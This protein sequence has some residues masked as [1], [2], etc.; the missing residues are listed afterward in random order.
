MTHSLIDMP[1]SSSLVQPPDLMQFQQWLNAGLLPMIQ[2][3]QQIRSIK[4]AWNLLSAGAELMR[5]SN[6]NI[7]SIEDICSKAGTTVGAFYGRFQNK[8]AFFLALQKLVLLQSEENMNR[9]WRHR[10]YESQSL[11]DVCALLVTASV[12]RY[13]QNQG[14]YRT[15]LQRAHEGMWDA[16]K[17]IGDETRVLLTQALSHQLDHI[18]QAARKLRVEFAHQTM[19]SVLSHAVQ[20]AP[21]PVHLRED[22]MVRELTNLLVAYLEQPEPGDLPSKKQ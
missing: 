5:E 21:S 13:R 17:D 7:L 1:S 12:E 14:V 15:S 6:F 2:P 16:F 3:S 11:R 4:T 19:I 20:N 9:L 8:D 18:P 10:T 22:T